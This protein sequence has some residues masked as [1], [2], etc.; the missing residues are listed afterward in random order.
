MVPIYIYSI[1][2]LWICVG[3]KNRYCSYLYAVF[4]PVEERKISTDKPKARLLFSTMEK[5]DI[6]L[7]NQVLFK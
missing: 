2:K 6:V 3:N 5:R 7:Y 4:C 1:Y